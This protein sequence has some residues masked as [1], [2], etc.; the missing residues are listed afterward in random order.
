MSHLTA[1]GLS[2][3]YRHQGTEVPAL[4]DVT[5]GVAPGEFLTLIG[6]SGCGKSTL[7]RCL[8]G[9]ERP[10]TG[11]VK[12]GGREVQ[13]P[14]PDRMMVFQ[15]FEQLFPWLTVQDNVSLA[16]RLTG[17]VPGRRESRQVARDYLN[18]VGL[19]AYGD[20]Y[21][22]QLSGGMKQRVAIARALSVRPQVLLM[23]EPFGSLDALTRNGLQQ[24]LLRIWQ[25]TGVTVI[26]VTHNIE[27]AV[28]LADRIAVLTPGPGRL[29]GI[30]QNPLPR[31]RSPEQPAFGE[32]W[33]QVHGELRLE[34][35]ADEPS[36]VSLTPV[37]SSPQ[38]WGRG[39]RAN[40]ERKQRF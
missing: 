22:H 37:T 28:L 25:E 21:P 12:V 33:E 7:L 13:G 4:H 19:T 30:L 3:V 16:L 27:E 31:P 9:F 17:N 39:G 8:A 26:F 2:K 1:S 38:A 15:G 29:R 20:Y 18:L 40:S 36:G 11:L 14:G 35:D 32:V 10:S 5:F 24:E 34:P 6:P 23:D